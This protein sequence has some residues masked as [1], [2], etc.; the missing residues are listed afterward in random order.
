MFKGNRFF[1]I[2][3]FALFPMFIFTACSPGQSYLARHASE[4]SGTKSTKVRRF[5]ADA[6]RESFFTTSEGITIDMPYRLFAPKDPKDGPFPI[7]LFL[8]GAGERGSDNDRQVDFNNGIFNSLTF[9]YF[10][11]EH[12]SIIIAP[13]CSEEQ[14]WTD[15]YMLAALM[16]LVEYVGD[17]YSGDANRLYVMGL[18][19]GGM[20][21][22]ALLEKYPHKIAA[23]IPICGNGD[24]SKADR[25]KDIPIWAFHG[26]NDDVVPVEGSREM[27][28]ALKATGSTTVKYTECPGVMHDSWNNAYKDPDLLNWM[29]SQS[30]E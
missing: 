5:P 24:P 6:T 15:G 12:P 23:A 8:H 9:K 29:F 25:F 11:E 13:Q 3:L 7:F 30:K 21:T 27:V 26:D 28:N 22:W 4:T 10:Y 20:G 19:M 18:S 2:F 14:W 17:I 1:A 16:S